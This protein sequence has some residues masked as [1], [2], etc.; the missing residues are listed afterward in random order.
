MRD[1]T[2]FLSFYVIIGCMNRK[3]VL[4]LLAFIQATLLLS[5]VY[6]LVLPLAVIWKHVNRT[7]ASGWTRWTHKTE[8][9]VD[10]HQ[11]F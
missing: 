7:S 4:Q 8:T 5:L 11:Q 3:Q 9:L 6:I 2:R 10:F 1:Y